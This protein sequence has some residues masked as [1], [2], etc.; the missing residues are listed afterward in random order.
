MK[1]MFNL[2]T[3]VSVLVTNQVPEIRIS[4]FGSAVGLGQVERGFLFNFCQIIINLPNYLAKIEEK[5]GS[6]CL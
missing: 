1:K 5:P 2:I 3:N 4:S 6:T